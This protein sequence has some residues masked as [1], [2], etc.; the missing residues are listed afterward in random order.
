MRGCGV[1]WW[2]GRSRL[3]TV[4]VIVAAAADDSGRSPW[5]QGLG[6]AHSSGAV[7][8]DCHGWDYYGV[9]CHFCRG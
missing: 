8:S 7:R 9:V 1:L 5:I 4:D 2:G 6:L 3:S